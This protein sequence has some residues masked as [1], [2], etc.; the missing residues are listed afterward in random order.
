MSVPYKSDQV[1]LLKVV[2]CSAAAGFESITEQF[3]R[4]RLKKN[5]YLGISH[6]SELKAV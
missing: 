4:G 3:Y 6:Q 5:P 1:P 2:N